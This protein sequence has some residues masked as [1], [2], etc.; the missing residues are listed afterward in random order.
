MFSI[1]VFGIW[2][3]VLRPLAFVVRSFGSICN[4]LSTIFAV[5]LTIATGPSFPIPTLRGGAVPRMWQALAREFVRLGHPTTI[6]ARAFDGQPSEETLDGTRILRWGGFDQSR[7]VKR[8]LGKDFIYAMGVARRLPAADILVTNDFWLPVVAPRLSP[9]AGKIVINAN[10]FPK[11]QYVLYGGAS[12]VA[13]ASCAV[14]DAIK[15]QCPKMTA[16]V[17]VLPNPIDP[18]LFPESLA[19]KSNSISQIL[20]VGRIHPE[21]GVHLLLD[22][23][24]LLVGRRVSFSC[25]LVGP[26]EESA[27]GGGRGYWDQLHKTSDGL[28]VEWTG[29][30]F[31][32]SQ[33]ARLYQQTDLFC[34]P[35]LADRGESFGLAPLESMAAGV[36]AVVSRLKCFEDFIEPGVTGWYFNHHAAN[37]AELLANA[38]EAA[39]TDRAKREAVGLRARDTARKFTVP[40]VAAQ[41][42]NAFSQTLKVGRFIG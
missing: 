41:Y 6:F 36:P 21:K 4:F 39:L 18:A 13:A 33:L 25:R 42:L 38:L 1:L 14:A 37:A 24:R 23:V 28:P 22:A 29:P 15:E 16:R 30:I 19:P 27:G 31:E 3:L 17:R 8:D 12:L 35:S 5:N 2:R 20:F 10:R 26:W 7:S 34:Y 40:V 9:R 11:K 32:L